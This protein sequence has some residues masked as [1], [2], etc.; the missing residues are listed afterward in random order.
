MK[1]TYELSGA[2]TYMVSPAKGGD[3]A[4]TIREGDV[5]VK[6]TVVPGG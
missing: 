2:S 3:V 5:A 4:L 1:T 6:V